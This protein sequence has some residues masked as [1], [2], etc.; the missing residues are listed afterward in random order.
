MSIPV[1][2]VAG[3]SQAARHRVIRDA[4][5]K[6]GLSQ[7]NSGLSEQDLSEQDLS[8]QD[9]ASRVAWL[10]HQDSLIQ[11]APAERQP[12]Q[13]FVAC[14][15]CAGSLVFT[16][17]LGRILRQG[18]WAGL[19]ISLG[20]RAEPARMLRLLS[21]AP[22]SDH[23]GPIRL[24]SVM[25]ETSLALCELKDHCLHQIAHQQKTSAEQ[26]L[27]PGDSLPKDLFGLG[28]PK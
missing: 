10:D 22:W 9:H 7:A 6:A 15:C 8:E 4:L 1:V 12:D 2:L 13:S 25:D 3:F 24:F 26:V 17:H 18:P 14:V 5:N 28:R 11:A 20:A 27:R 21:L 16:T 23:L 19:M